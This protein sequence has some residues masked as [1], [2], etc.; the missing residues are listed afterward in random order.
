MVQRVVKISLILSLLLV[1]ISPV[2]RAQ[3][4]TPPPS[5]L[6]AWYRGE[7]NANDSS[8]NGFHGLLANAGTVS[9]HVGQ[10]FNFTTQTDSVAIANNP[11]LFPPNALTVEAW[12]NPSSYSGCAG[13][14]RVFHTVQ[15]VIR[16]YATI[17]NCEGKFI[18]AIFDS[19]EVPEAVVSNAAIPAGTFTHIAMTWD[20][21]NL[22]VYINGAL[23][24]VAPTT[25]SA[26]GTNTH[27]LRIGNATALG[28]LGRIDEVSLY[29]RA[30]SGAEISAIFSAGTVGKC[31]APTAANV[32][33]SGRVTTA[34]GV[35]IG[36]IRLALAAANG[37]VRFARTSPFGY[38][39]FDDV[40]AGN[41]YVITAFNSKRYTL[42]EPTRFV[43]ASDSI[44]DVDFVASP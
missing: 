41:S 28:F 37:S 29:D 4:C 10:A 7:G 26:I 8:G 34:S 20:G 17:L 30:L 38:Y 6:V 44:T 25:M 14:Y 35:G 23:D 19:N 21:A 11:G 18:G 22:R 13:S 40:E 27:D 9:G 31:F 42:A 43:S 39:R 36:G 5:G 24:N 33:I 15:T 2:S 16:G 12:V 3:V 32:S 1:V